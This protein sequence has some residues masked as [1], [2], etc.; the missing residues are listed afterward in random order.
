VEDIFLIYNDGR[1]ISH[2][3]RRLDTVDDDVLSAMLTALQDFTK[4]SFKNKIEGSLDEFK[5]G[6]LRFVIERGKYMLLA[7]GIRNECPNSLRNAMKKT[8]NEIEESCNDIF[9]SWNGQMN[10]VS[11]VK[12]FI[13]KNLGDFISSNALN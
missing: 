9:L 8:L 13:K 12:S 7:V 10:D 2:F 5:Y 6:E 3:T 4:D 11:H 1:L